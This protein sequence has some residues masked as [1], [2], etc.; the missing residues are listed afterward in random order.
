MALLVTLTTDFEERDPH[1]AFVKGVLCSR[2]PGAQIVDLTHEIPRKNVMEAALF[3]AGATPYFPKG[4]VH[5][6]CVFAGAR[7][8]AVSINDQ[9]IVC[10]DNGVVS[11]LAEEYEI[12]E[13]REITNPDLILSNGGQTYFG[14]DVFAPVA[15]ALASGESISDV[16]DV[17]D[18]ITLMDFPKPKKEGSSSVSGQVIHVDHFGNLVTNIHRGFLSGLEVTKIE[19]AGFPIHGISDTYADVEVGTP[20]VLI[21]SAGLLEIAYNGDRADTRL[22]TRIGNMVELTVK[23]V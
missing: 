18:D 17:V 19:V 23:S 8:I 2:C 14:R 3:V 6:V 10:P 15:A 12:Q 21:G 16:G 20:L 13:V 5:I 1:V 22:N 7:P 11:F 4:T 9:F